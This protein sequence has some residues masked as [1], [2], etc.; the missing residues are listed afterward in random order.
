L[1]VK[2]IG[3]QTNILC[4][5]QILDKKQLWVNKKCGCQK[6]FVYKKVVAKKLGAE[7]TFGAQKNF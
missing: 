7:E 6:K 5:K 3:G 2:K 4:P 1:G